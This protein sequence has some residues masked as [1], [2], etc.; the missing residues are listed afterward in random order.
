ME[1]IKNLT[2][3]ETMKGI[4]VELMKRYPESC[5][6]YF[7]CEPIPGSK[8][9]RASYGEYGDP[10]DIQDMGIDL[11]QYDNRA[12]KF[13]R[14]TTL[15]EMANLR[16]EDFNH[17]IPARLHDAMLDYAI[18]L[19]TPIKGQYCRDHPKF[20]SL[21][22]EQNNKYVHKM[23]QSVKMEELE[24]HISELKEEI[25]RLEKLRSPLNMYM[26]IESEIKRLNKA[27]K[28]EE[29]KSRKE[30]LENIKEKHRKSAELKNKRIEQCAKMRQAKEKKR[31]NAEN[32]HHIGMQRL[33]KDH[34]VVFPPAGIAG[35]QA[36]RKFR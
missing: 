27:G 10:S 16:P 3:S 5:F 7:A 1:I 2:L 13:C 18:F 35:M 33:G 4:K 28:I 34:I 24:I 29:A 14:D 15:S 11:V 8:N 17:E 20:R 30:E 9:K 6:V 23:G 21:L 22:T 36:V 26:L 32:L 31:N 12:K 25:N 19:G